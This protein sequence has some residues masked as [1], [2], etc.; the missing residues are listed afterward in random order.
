MP[1]RIVLTTSAA[2]SGWPRTRHAVNAYSRRWRT[3]APASGK[4]AVELAMEKEAGLGSLAG[5][6]R[7]MQGFG[8]LRRQ[9]RGA[10]VPRPY[11]IASAS[12]RVTPSAA[13]YAFEIGAGA[14]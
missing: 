4:G 6:D 12:S 3:V 8:G 7:R 13:D 1:K 14:S 9:R 10:L 11:S 2:R 5:R